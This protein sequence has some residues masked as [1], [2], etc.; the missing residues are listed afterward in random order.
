MTAH[1]LEPTVILPLFPDKNRANSRFH[2]IVYAARTSTTEKHK[3]FVMCIEYHFLAFAHVSPRKHHPAVAEPDMRNLHGRRHTAQNNNLMAPDPMGMNSGRRSARVKPFN[4]FVSGV[5]AM[6]VTQTHSTLS[7]VNRTDSAAIF[8]SLELSLSTWLVT[9]TSP[10]S[11][12]RMSKHSVQGG[13]ISALLERLKL[14]QQKAKVQTGLEYPVIT[15]QE[16]GLDGFWL[17]R[18]CWLTRSRVTSWTPHL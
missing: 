1:L 14:L 11:G 2:I 5:S 18:V 10:G 16:A 6:V 7:N 15:I 12:D 9:S 4:S 17:H 3:S 13:D 8:V